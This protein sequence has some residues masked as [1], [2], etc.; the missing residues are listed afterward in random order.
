MINR[1]RNY[2]IVEVMGGDGG[3][4]QS[5]LRS[6]ATEER[7]ISNSSPEDVAFHIVRE[8]VFLKWTPEN[9]RANKWLMH[10]PRGSP[11]VEPRFNYAHRRV[12][13]EEGGEVEG[14]E[15]VGK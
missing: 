13:G 4:G 9:A 14:G 5:A 12:R 10:A 15:E 3:D 8:V 2:Y 7:R 11:T 6:V 1:E